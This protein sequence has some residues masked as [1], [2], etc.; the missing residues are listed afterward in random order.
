[1]RAALSG[2]E[3]GEV[4]L[5]AEVPKLSGGEHGQVQHREGQKEP[6]VGFLE[7]LVTSFWAICSGSE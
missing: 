4:L 1:M 5:H 3:L 2:V 7:S 6:V